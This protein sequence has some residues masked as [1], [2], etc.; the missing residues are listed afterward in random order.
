MSRSLE[1][2]QPGKEEQTECPEQAVYELDFLKGRQH[3]LNLNGKGNIHAYQDTGVH[4]I[5]FLDVKT[6][7]T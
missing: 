7:K 5:G 3:N 6:T 1:T 2:K 4:G